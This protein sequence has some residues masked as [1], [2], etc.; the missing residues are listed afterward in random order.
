LIRSKLGTRPKKFNVSVLKCYA[1]G[2]YVYCFRI[3][4]EGYRGQSRRRLFD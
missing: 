2:R 4:G 1:C 3:E